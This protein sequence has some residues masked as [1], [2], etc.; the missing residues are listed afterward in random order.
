MVIT[1]YGAPAEAADPS[2]DNLALTT[3]HRPSLAT[4]KIRLE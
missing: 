3:Q 2:G 4:D 1:A